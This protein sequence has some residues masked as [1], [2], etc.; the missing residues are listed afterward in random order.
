[1]Y[2]WQHAVMTTP[3]SIISRY[4][5]SMFMP[6]EVACVY[7]MQLPANAASFSTWLLKVLAAQ[8]WRNLISEPSVEV[9]AVAWDFFLLDTVVYTDV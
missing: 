9:G 3:F 6:R 5:R 4:S 7:S 2:A 1:M 8:C